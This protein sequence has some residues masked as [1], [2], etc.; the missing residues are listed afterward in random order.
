LNG[1]LLPV[2]LVF[3]LLLINDRRLTG[4]LRNGPVQN[5]LGWGTVVLVTCAVVLLFVTT[6]F[7]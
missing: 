5:V 2:L 7:A 1:C 3:I 4:D 6:I